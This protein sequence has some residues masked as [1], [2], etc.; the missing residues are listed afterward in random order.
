MTHALARTIAPA[1]RVI[2]FI[3]ILP[4]GP[5]VGWTTDA[6]KSGVTKWGITNHVYFDTFGR[7]FLAPT[8]KFCDLTVILY[9]TL[10]R[11]V[12]HYFDVLFYNT[13]TPS[14]YYV[15]YVLL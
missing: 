10:I 5:A 13:G 4:G 1:A 14:V 9:C 8:P 15:Q 12:Y 2:R 11:I 6:D 7:E 3:A